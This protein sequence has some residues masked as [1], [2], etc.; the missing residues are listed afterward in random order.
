MQSLA[1]V[2]PD[3][4]S[5]STVD[6]VA[7]GFNIPDES[8]RPGPDGLPGVRGWAVRHRILLPADARGGQMTER[9]FVLSQDCLLGCDR[10]AGVSAR[11]AQRAG[12]HH[13]SRA[14]SWPRL[15]NEYQPRQVN[16]G[17]VDPASETMKLATLGL[18]GVAVNLLWEKANYYKKSKTGPTSPPRSSN[19]PSCSRTS[20]RSGSSRPGT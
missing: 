2:L 5:F 1:Y 18:R 9:T 4:R 8:A 20:S 15:R 10:R 17:E 16:L 14:A 12:D 3:F 19:S 6:Y 11:L 13:E 7:Y